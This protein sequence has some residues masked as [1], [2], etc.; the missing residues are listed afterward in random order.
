ME[1]SSEGEE[2]LETLRLFCG[3]AS[4]RTGGEWKVDVCRTGNSS[5]G[6][7]LLWIYPEPEDAE[8]RDDPQRV[9]GE[10]FLRAGT[11]V[12]LV[13]RIVEETRGDRFDMSALRDGHEFWPL[14]EL[15]GCSSREELRFRL[16][17]T[18]PS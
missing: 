4:A 17:V 7:Q 10:V 6:S 1:I 13:G 18:Q 12:D 2:A 16:L 9:A 15:T 8:S 3:A 14:P 5:I 11:V